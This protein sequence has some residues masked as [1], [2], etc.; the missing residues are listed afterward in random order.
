MAERL[1]RYRPLGVSIASIP[2]VDYTQTAK[3]RASAYESL[4]QSLDR[5]SEFAFKR[6]QAKTVREAEQYAFDN[7]I[8][9]EQIQDAKLK[10]IDLDDI[11]GDPDTVFGATLRATTGKIMR[12]DLEGAYRTSIVA[13]QKNIESPDW[14][15]SD[16]DTGLAA[17]VNKLRDME[18]G[19]TDALAE[20]DRGEAIAFK[21]TTATLGSAVYKTALETANK[22]TALMMRMTAQQQSDE[23]EDVIVGVIRGTEFSG[24]AADF[25]VNRQELDALIG[26]ASDS[27][28]SAMFRSGD[29]T[30]AEQEVAGIQEKILSAK[31]NVLVEHS[32]AGGI[33]KSNAEIMYN[34]SQGDFGKYSVIYNS[35]S[36]KEKAAVREMVRTEMNARDSEREKRIRD[37]NRR[38]SGQAA[39]LVASLDG[40]ESDQ[41]EAVFD[42]L[43]DI[44]AA[45]GQAAITTSTIQSIRNEF[46]QETKSN[47]RGNLMMREAIQRGEVTPENFSQKQKEYGV[48]HKDAVSLFDKMISVDKAADAEV[49]RMARA[50]ANIYDEMSPYSDEQ[51]KQVNMFMRKV[52]RDYAVSVA[53]WEDGGQTGPK[54]TRLEAAQGVQDNIISQAFT[55]NITR[56]LDA[57]N[58]QLRPN[59][60]LTFST[61]V[62]D[63]TTTEQDIDNLQLV[64]APRPQ[65][66][67]DE[68]KILL[69]SLQK[70]IKARENFF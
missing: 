26:T 64:N 28:R 63:E 43:Y 8:S 11:V 59:E 2:T 22:K 4:A 45:T 39:R 68:L 41:R 42:E 69:F 35:M 61:F 58:K 25:A 16:P 56:I 66:I 62:I 49:L 44:S 60:R 14:N 31:T 50:S 3:V 13:L 54:P 15:P 67:K 29:A 52:E 57:M 36:A 46:E 19:Y 18:M 65:A 17:T 40:M 53:E 38:Q 34:M 47:H 33:L 24:S 1:P 10:G 7:P 6:L 9:I 55:Q 48:I 21:A 30:F 5:V 20:V 37:E 23:F 32:L 51:A 70:E 12:T 27:F